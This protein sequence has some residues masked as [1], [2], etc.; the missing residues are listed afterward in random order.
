MLMKIDFE[1][2][3]SEL[4]TELKTTDGYLD[5]EHII[6]S[7]VKKQIKKNVAIPDI[8]NYLKNL[9]SYFEEKMVINNGHMDSINF[10]YAAGFLSTLIETP[11]WQSWM[12]TSR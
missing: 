2:E 5:C 12:K 9:Q 8:E 6:V 11:Y 10:R 3:L 1:V 7:N 4:T